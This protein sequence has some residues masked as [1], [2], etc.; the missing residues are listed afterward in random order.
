[1]L[2]SGT[3]FAQ[4]ASDVLENGIKIKK[5]NIFLNPKLT[6]NDK[7]LEYSSTGKTQDFK[8]LSDSTILQVQE[9]YKIY[10]KAL[11][12]LTYSYTDTTFLHI[13]PINQAAIDAMGKITDILSKTKTA[14]E[15]KLVQEQKTLKSLDN[16]SRGFNAKSKAITQS[17]ISLE[18]QIAIIELVKEI[19][20]SIAELNSKTILSCF[21]DLKNLSFL[22]KES[23][24]NE[25]AKAK[26]KFETMQ[27]RVNT[28]ET[29]IGKAHMTITDSLEKLAFF[30]EEWKTYF[31]LGMVLKQS[32]EVKNELNRHIKNL[33]QVIAFTE[34]EIAGWDNYDIDRQWYIGIESSLLKHG[35]MS[36]QNIKL[37]ESGYSIKN[38]VIIPT[39]RKQLISA[40]FWLR[41]QNIFVPE[42]AAG[43]F[44]SDLR[45][46]VYGTS[47]NASGETIIGEARQESIN[48][49]N[50]G[51]T[52]NFTLNV[53]SSMLQPFW[54]LGAGINKDVMPVV[55]TGIGLRSNISG[56]RR[57][58]I[59]GGIMMS[60][61][62]QLD[63]LKVGDVI[64]GTV[65]IENDLHYVFSWPPK[66]Y[67][68][69]QYNF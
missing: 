8:K 61:T 47:T 36:L 45:Y 66:P 39:D 12:P 68:G 18:K 31:L 40:T 15:N 33:Q 62:Q 51:T 2:V 20:D 46:P 1:M 37:Y 34:K 10:V 44:Y 67:I 42:V 43:I 13:D 6:G 16:K 57:F 21:T 4:K 17:S 55:F 5:G 14:A 30:N 24:K 59:A 35:K 38:S 64:S 23:T 7:Y 22:N 11:N 28:I 3:L 69:I 63:Q 29:M 56:L 48:R 54:Q 19:N 26:N 50:I 58:A 32:E 9:G 52:I 49:M 41:R 65:D 60:W 27:Q 53:P 25:I